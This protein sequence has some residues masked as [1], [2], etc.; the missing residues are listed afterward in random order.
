MARRGVTCENSARCSSGSA[1][2]SPGRG[3]AGRSVQSVARSRSVRGALGEFDP[4]RELLEREPA[5]ADGIAQHN[6]DVLAIGV[7]GEDRRR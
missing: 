4:L 1:V 3:A 7:G 5:L 2:S 6:R